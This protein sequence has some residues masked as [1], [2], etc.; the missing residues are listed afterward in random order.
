MEENSMFTFTVKSQSN[1]ASK[2]K[3]YKYY[4]EQLK[5]DITSDRT[6]TRLI[7]EV[8]GSGYRQT[9]DIL[10]YSDYP[11]LYSDRI[12]HYS[13][14][15]GSDEGEITKSIWFKIEEK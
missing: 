11:H 5:D 8:Y 7:S 9:R 1:N 12:M 14:V 6:Q 13:I 10:V 4:D 2:P 3:Y 15:I